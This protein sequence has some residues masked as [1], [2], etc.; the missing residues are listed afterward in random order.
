MQIIIS[1]LLASIISLII[2]NHEEIEA[3]IDE[4]IDAIKKLSKDSKK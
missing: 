2:I 3:R 4:I 1:M